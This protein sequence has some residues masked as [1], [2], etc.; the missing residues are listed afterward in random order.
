MKKIKKCEVTV[1]VV[2]RSE[3]TTFTAHVFNHL[4]VCIN[5]TAPV[6]G[7]LDPTYVRAALKSIRRQVEWGNGR[8]FTADE[9][10]A[11][12]GGEPYTFPPIT[13]EKL[14]GFVTK[15]YDIAGIALSHNTALTYG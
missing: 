14:G 12:I 5:L 13:V 1:S 3:Q 6:Y 7:E 9:Q 11:V 15:L 8:E 10:T 4:M 2:G